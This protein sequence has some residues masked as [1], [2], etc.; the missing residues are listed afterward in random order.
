MSDLFKL[1]ITH[2]ILAQTYV[3]R[4][5]LNLKPT[6]LWVRV[7][8]GQGQGRY[9]TTLGLP[10][11]ITSTCIVQ[12]LSAKK[13]G[14]KDPVTCISCGHNRSLVQ[15]LSAKITLK[16]GFAATPATRELL[17]EGRL[18]TARIFEA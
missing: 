4:L 14:I 18:F 15:G 6:G 12:G 8:E 5:V 13:N 11:T 9:A 17:N 1:A 3:F 16:A 2:S 7:S 10:L